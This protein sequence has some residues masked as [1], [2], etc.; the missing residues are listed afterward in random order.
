[1]TVTK[2]LGPTAAEPRSPT[3]RSSA[4]ARSFSVSTAF[5]D[6]EGD[7]DPSFS[8]D[9]EGDDEAPWEL[10]GEHI[11]C[12]CSRIF[13]AQRARELNVL[14]PSSGAIDQADETS[15]KSNRSSLDSKIQQRLS[16]KKSKSRKVSTHQA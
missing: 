14:I 3:G 2:D 16:N 15:L 6:M 5:A 10:S 7:I 12:F 9:V 4:H 1:M 13:E 11:R 8:F